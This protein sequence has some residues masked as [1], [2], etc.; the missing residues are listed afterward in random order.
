MSRTIW[1]WISSDDHG[2]DDED[3]D[4]NPDP[5]LSFGA[6]SHLGSGFACLYIENAVLIE[7]PHNHPSGNTTTNEKQ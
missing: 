3:D 4:D 1:I 5:R 7:E 6:L 2:E